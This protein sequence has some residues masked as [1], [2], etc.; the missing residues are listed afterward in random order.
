MTAL[1]GLSG[2]MYCLALVRSLGFYS[3]VPQ[4]RTEG[5]QAQW[6]TLV[7]PAYG[8]LRPKDCHKFAASWDWVVS[9]GQLGYRVKPYLKKKK[10]GM[11]R[12][13]SQQS[14]CHAVVRTC[15]PNTHFKKKKMPA[16][17]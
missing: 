11:R 14:A 15:T 13:P 3:L 9:L 8:R 17:W 2:G 6:P 12:W 5:S 16:V 4:K 1:T 10:Y 7:I